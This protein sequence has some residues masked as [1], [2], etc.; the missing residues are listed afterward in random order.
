MYT[1]GIGTSGVIHRLVQTA[2]DVQLP[3]VILW[4]LY[5]TYPS[6]FPIKCVNCG[7]FMHQSH[8]N[9]GSSNAKQHRTL[10]GIDNIVLLIS[11]VYTCNSKHKILAHDDVILELVPKTSIPFCLESS[12]MAAN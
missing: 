2:N 5:I 9:D 6:S 7:E 3:T 11:A 12:I 8:W 1:I 10:H 4:N